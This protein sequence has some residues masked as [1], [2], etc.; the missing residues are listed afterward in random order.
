MAINLQNAPQNLAQPITPALNTA[1]PI[2]TDSNNATVVSYDAAS[3]NLNAGGL[4]GADLANAQSVLKSS[5]QNPN[6]TIAVDSL[7]KPVAPLA[8]PP[9][10]TPSNIL[11]GAN[12]AGQAQAGNDQ[13]IQQQADAQ[14]AAQSKVDTGT[15]TVQSYIDKLIGKG[16]AQADLEAASGISAKTQAVNSITNEYNA[17]QLK[18]RRQQEAILNQPGVTREGAQGALAEVSRQNNAELADIAIRQS[19]ANND[20]TT[21][22]SIIDH[23]IA[24][25][26]GDLKDVINYQ[27]QF[28]Q[29]N[30]DDLSKAQ[31]NKLQLQVTDNTRKYEAATTA[32]KSLEDAKLKVLA[33]AGEA[34]APQSVLKAIQAATTPEKAFVAAGTYGAGLDR[35]VKLANI[36]QSNAS[37]AASYANAAKTRA[38]IPGGGTTG[39]NGNFAATIGLAANTGGTNAQRAAV[40]TNLQ[41]L[42][43]QKDYP[44]AY[45]AILQATAG[46][47]SGTNKADFQ[48]RLEQYS[49]TQDLATQLKSLKDAGYDTNKLTGG[50]D[51][52][53]TKIGALTTDPKYAAVANQLNLAYQNYRHQMTGA[54]FSAAEAAQY[55]SVLPGAG[56]T[57]ALNSAKI[58]G[59]NN[60]LTSTV[61][62]YTKQVVG[63]GGVEIRKY[64]QGEVPNANNAPSITVAGQTYTVG[65]LLQNAL[66]QK[67]RVNADG[68]ITPI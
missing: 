59:L 44:S 25:Q 61:D 13:L 37:A 33:G 41:S 4:Q 43:M 40:K 64:A 5:Y 19:A 68:T 22:Q 51:A 48:N 18:F 39:Y 30:K 31:Q 16:Q 63:Q 26:Y 50:A 57:F 9:A 47:L 52:I 34:G 10:T 36:A 11:A 53:G 20:L 46:G 23:K 49:V 58:D 60:F 67:G 42:I 66:G 3:K 45:A 38:E 1:A 54:A 12:I 8:T 24:L 65:S 14:N 6:P 55:A 21:A 2:T 17:K 62:G 7:N 27:M 15:S 29:S 56:N 32:A 28:L 35:Q